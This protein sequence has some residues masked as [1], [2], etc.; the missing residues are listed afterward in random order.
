MAEYPT[1]PRIR[2]IL[3]QRG[4]API[5]KLGQ[6]F[7]IDA[8]IARKALELAGLQSTDTVIEIGPG[9]G[10]ISALLLEQGCPL[11]AVEKDKGF[12]LYLCETLKLEY[13]DTFHLIHEDALNYP[14]ANFTA[15][16]E[17]KIIAN[18]PYAISTPWMDAVLSGHLPSKMVIMLQKETADR[19]T[20]DSNSGNFGPISIFLNSAYD[21]DT[22]Y[23]VGASCFFPQPIVGSAL[24]SIQRKATPILFPTNLREGIREIFRQRRKQIQSIIPKLKDPSLFTDWLQQLVNAGMS[25]TNR[26]EAITIKQWQLLVGSPCEK[27]KPSFSR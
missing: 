6:N 15:D 9:L 11:Y 2:E 23:K 16:T 20:G 18:L 10:A 25:P 5:K 12:H 21:L 3:S 8:N 1:L 4:L 24:L 13:P 14:L 7:L 17:F 22:S 27:N 19:F 26:P